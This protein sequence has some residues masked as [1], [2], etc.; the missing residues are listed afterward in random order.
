M[1]I[2]GWGRY[3]VVDARIERPSTYAEAGLLLDRK[4]AV[5]RIAR[6]MGRSYGDSAL[7]GNVVEMRRLDHFL[8]FD[9]STGAL[10]CSAGVTLADILSV[11]VPRG[12]TLP[13]V[14]GTRY[15]SVGG[16][17]ASD[18]HG[19]NHHRSGCFSEYV[20]ELVLLTG[21]G[22]TR[23]CS[24]GSHADLFQATCGGL[25]LTGI[26][27]EACIR[28]VRINS[29]LIEQTTYKA[30][31]LDEALDL[32]DTHHAATYSVAW[33]DCLATGKAM[34]RSLV[35]TGEPSAEAMPAG[36][37]AS[38]SAAALGVPVEMPSAL[39]NRYSIQAFNTL[40]YQRVREAQTRQQ[41]PYEK[42]FFPLD[43]IDGWNRLYGKNG[44]VQY[45]FVL[46]KAAGKQ[47]MKAILQRITASRRGS[48]LA[49]LKALGPH[50]GNLLSFPLEGHTLALDFKMEAGVLA[51]LD[52]LDAMVNDHGG[53][54]YLAKDARMSA[55][56]FRSQYSRWEA[57]QAIREHYGAIG[58]FAS[59]QSKRLGL[60]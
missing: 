54:V 47:A 46:P 14:P 21:D 15:V 3:P 60:D 12:W 16:A 4:E 34:G 53:R 31:S 37:M 32:F 39:L 29:T 42:F 20:D 43:G 41:V 17:I 44:F 48:F 35:M 6:G 11:F 51:L 25:G 5:P 45:Q 2:S 50:N 55:A 52:E 33:I 36:R 27:L 40:Y 26:V 49:V 9:E 7:A 23:A 57:F 13:V 10:R 59:L 8:H 24:R 58:R 19:K 38:P 56:A 18:V 22:M 1:L 30:A 28:L